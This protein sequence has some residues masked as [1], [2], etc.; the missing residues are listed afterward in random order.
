MPH[1]QAVSRFIE[2]LK[3]FTAQPY[4]VHFQCAPDNRVPPERFDYHVHEFWEVKL[5]MDPPKISLHAPETVHCSTVSDMVLSITEKYLQVDDLAIYPEE[6]HLQILL[7][8]LNTIQYMQVV[9]GTGAGTRHAAAALLANILNTLQQYASSAARHLA[10]QNPAE[11]VLD[12]LKHHYY[13]CDLSVND[14]AEHLNISAQTLN[15]ILR[16]T[17]GMSLRKH[18]INI[19]ITQAERL[20]ANP[21]YLIKEV[22]VLTGWRSPYYFCNSFRKYHGISPQE[23]RSNTFRI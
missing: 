4:T 19:R 9:S 21:D 15:S 22:A 10:R 3:I 8:L 5:S 18:L 20:L 12:Y 1:T 11:R 13:C 23:W 6:K 17:T 7:L 16:K 14:A 2:L